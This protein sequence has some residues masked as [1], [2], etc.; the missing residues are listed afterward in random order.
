MPPFSRLT[1]RV[2]Y[3]EGS[4]ELTLKVWRD[5]LFLKR[6]PVLS[7]LL[8]LSLVSLQ[9]S[10]RSTRRRR[11]CGAGYLGRRHGLVQ[12]L[13]ISYKYVTRNNFV[14]L[15]YVLKVLG[16]PYHC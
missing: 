11:G 8:S 9:V 12:Q 2:G 7:L 4:A 3:E 14:S 1:R 15:I 16:A 5:G 13:Q 6:H 10:L